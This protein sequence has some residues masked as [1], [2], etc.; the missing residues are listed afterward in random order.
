MRIL[1]I[2]SAFLRAAI[3]K[4]TAY[5]AE[6][7]GNLFRSVINIGVAVGGLAVVFS[8]TSEL[9]G[10]RLEQ[11][12]VLLGVYYLVQGIVQTALSP[13]LNEVVTEVRKGTFD[14]VLLKPVPSLL[15]SST[16]RFVVWHVADVMLGGAII[17]IGLIRLEAQ[18]TFGVAAV[19]AGV[20][21]GGIAIVFSIWLAL[22]TLVFWFVRV[23]NITMI[24]QL[25]FDTGRYPVEIYPF[26]LR[27][28]LT[29]VFPVAFITTVPAQTITGREPLVAI[30]LAP[31]IGVLTLLAAARFWRIGLSRYTSASS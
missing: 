2:V 19:F 10:W 6:L 9:S 8:H 20:M 1:R 30:W 3:L 25:F 26:W 5:R 4:E 27:S 23:E 31:L 18:I 24:F 22:T 7:V 15:L 29:F 13:S 17:A 14:Y 21:V 16:R 11:A 12:M 28:L